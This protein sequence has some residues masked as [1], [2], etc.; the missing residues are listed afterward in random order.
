MTH[1]SEQQTRLKRIDKQLD[2]LGWPEASDGAEP[3]VGPY[4]KP[5]IETD[6]GPADYG[7]YKDQQLIGIVEAKKFRQTY[8][9]A[10]LAQSKLWPP[11]TVCITIAANI[12]HTGVLGFKAT[13]PD[14]VVGVI[15]DER[16]TRGAYLELFLR[17]AR[18][19]LDRFAP[20]TAQKNINLAILND[21]AVP[22]P[23]LAEQDEIVERVT[24]LLRRLNRVQEHA[25]SAEARLEAVDGALLTAA[26]RSQ[27]SVDDA[28]PSEE[29]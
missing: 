8:N 22:V 10:G 12:A 24:S 16:I 20:A 13:F 2:A 14:S 19:D 5:E 26:L 28:G 29:P 21:V 6:S 25:S 11:G 4:R 1:E 9:E 17:T 3:A 7:L 27:A 23:P 15:P 18:A